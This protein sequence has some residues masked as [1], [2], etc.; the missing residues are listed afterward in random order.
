MRAGD[1]VAAP[2]WIA[3][4]LDAVHD[5]AVAE[6]DVPATTVARLE[7]AGLTVTRLPRHDSSTGHAHLIVIG[8]DGSFDVG[9]DPRADGEAAAF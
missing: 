7:G 2:R 6:E 8:E 1:A 9:T 5:T 4:G 3:E